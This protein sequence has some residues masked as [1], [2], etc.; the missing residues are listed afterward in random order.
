VFDAV[1]QVWSEAQSCVGI[2]GQD[3]A[4]QAG[5]AWP[6]P[7]F[8]PLVSRRNDNG[9]GGGM[10][11]NGICDGSEI[12]DGTILDAL[13][14]LVWLRDAFCQ[15]FP[16]PTDWPTALESVASLQSGYC[17]LNDDSVAGD[18]R[19]PNVKE[20]QSLIDFG[21]FG[22]ALPVG[23][24]FANVPSDSSPTD[25]TNYW[26][27]TTAVVAPAFA[28]IGYAWNID[29]AFGI[30]RQDGKFNGYGRRVWAVRRQIKK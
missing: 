22:P 26:A 28:A 6:V 30:I 17:G 12:C 13:T 24:P 14:G 15:H 7:R 9:A 10:S 18:W 27:S 19:L 11:R 23:H 29:L 2:V 25:Q 4:V 8:I 1:N 5:V 21:Q 16:N 3:G 20:L